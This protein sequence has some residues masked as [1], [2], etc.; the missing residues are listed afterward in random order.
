MLSNLIKLLRGTAPAANTSVP[1]TATHSPKLWRQGDVFV[2]VVDAVPETV[3][4][5]PLPHGVLAHG[6]ITGHS[7]QFE[8]TENAQLYAGSRAGELFVE[9]AN[10]NARIVHDEHGTIELRPG[11]YRVWR[12]REY[13][14]ERIVH[15]AD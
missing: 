5:S 15:V 1:E 2:E 14:P 8:N 7:H 10:D 9:I 13:T 11:T 12:Q 6:E 4:R 3:M